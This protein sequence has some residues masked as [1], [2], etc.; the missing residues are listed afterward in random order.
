MKNSPLPEAAHKVALEVAAAT[1]M[2]VM[3]EILDYSG[4]ISARVP[5][6][7]GFVIQRRTDSRSEVEPENLVF[8]GYDG[9]I[10]GGNGKPPSETVIHTTIFNHRPDVQSVLHCHMELAIAFTMMEGVTLVPMRARASRW[11]SGIPT[12]PD[13]SHI[14]LPEQGEA[15][16]TTLG[17]HH[18]ALMRAHGLVMAA[19]SAQALVGDAV[20]FKENA[21]V[22]LTAMQ[23]GAKPVPLTDAEIKQILA[24][25]DRDQH[26]GKLW[27]YYVRKAAGQG[28][29]PAQWSQPLLGK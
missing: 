6:E 27:N 19:E 12:H 17:K 10:R 16:A 23:A 5:G 28:V 29:I 3:E 21:M 11:R 8:V 22:Q 14:K 25:E 2:L 24:K 20:H 9:K 18:A 7:D 4:H 26:V 15:L 1:R 13:P